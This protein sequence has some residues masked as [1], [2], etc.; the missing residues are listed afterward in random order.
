MNRR[1]KDMM[2]S[3]LLTH[4]AAPRTEMPMAEKVMEAAVGAQATER[5]IAVTI[6]REHRQEA[7]A[8]C[9]EG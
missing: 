9:R 7:V 1:P 8:M 2:W 4:L 5:R 6:P 3:R